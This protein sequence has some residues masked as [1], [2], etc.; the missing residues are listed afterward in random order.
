MRKKRIF[1]SNSGQNSGQIFAQKLITKYQNLARWSR[2]HDWLNTRVAFSV[3]QCNK[4]RF[5]TGDFAMRILEKHNIQKEDSAMN[6]FIYYLENRCT[7]KTVKVDG[8]RY[9][10]KRKVIDENTAFEHQLPAGII[11]SFKSYLE[12]IAYSNQGRAGHMNHYM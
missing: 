6:D 9:F 12:I 2:F 3:L 5:I 7:K 11:W 8:N 10:G 4:G 1:F